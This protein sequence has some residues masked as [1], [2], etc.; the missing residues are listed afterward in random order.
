MKQH[1]IL[2]ILLV[3]ATSCQK[4]FLD[5]LPLD[6][7]SDATFFSSK[8]ELNLAINGAYT[9]LWWESG[10]VPYTLYLEATTDIAWSRG[11]YANVQTVQAGQFTPDAAI[12]GNTWSWMYSSISKCNNILQNM[13]RAKDVVPADFYAG[14]QAQATFLRSYFY[15]WLVE[16]YGDV[17]YVTTMLSLDSADLAQTPKKEIVA[18]LYEDLDA[19][20]A[21]LPLSWSGSDEGRATKG[22]ALAL[23]ARLALDEGDYEVAAAAAKAVMDLGV[24]SIHPDYNELFHYEG[25]GS[26]EIILVLPYLTGVKTNIIPQIEGPRNGSSYSILVPTQTMVDQYAC[27]DG[28]PIDESPYYDPEHPFEHRDPR[29]DQSIIRPGVWFNNYLFQTHPDSTQTLQAVGTDTVRA[30]N[31]EVTNAYATF[32]GYLWRKWLNESDFPTKVTSSEQNVILI[33]YAEVLLTYAEAKIELGQIDQSVADAINEVRGRPGVEMPPV[34]AGM[35][36][37]ELRKTVRYE[38]TVELAD[39]GFRLMDIRRWKY[40]EHVMPGK[41]YGRRTKAHWYDAVKPQIDEYGHP[42]YPD[43]DQ[44]FKTISVNT[45]DPKKHYLW[46]IPQKEIDVNRNLKQ[47]PGY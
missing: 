25:K 9:G 14:I 15:F 41:V 23:K 17:P 47:N 11:D 7:P 10:S 21:V 8:D 36:Q 13:D 22:A 6:S 2:L 33:R 30:G 44:L 18:H 29:L 40:A 1:L 42:V 43:A 5:K 19:A 34:D 38:R 26:S 28:K 12:F 32:T 46:P 31:L 35:T 3:A 4:G 27:I 24:Y 39:E 45:F 16:L 20:A 37:A